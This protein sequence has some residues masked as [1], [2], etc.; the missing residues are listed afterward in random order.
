MKRFNIIFISVIVVST[1]LFAGINII[2]LNNSS[3]TSREYMVQIERLCSQIE[4]NEEYK[5]SDYPLIIN[6]EKCENT[7]DVSF[8]E[9]DNS[10]YAIR[11]I[12][13]SY[14]RFDY[15]FDSNRIN[16]SSVIMTDICLAVLL[17][18]MLTTLIFV[19]KQI[20]IPFIKLRDIPHELSKGNLTV[21]LK[22]NKNRLFGR[23]IWGLDLLREH[24]EQQKK[25]ELALIKDKKT[26]ILSISH[27]IK[28]PLS[29]IKLSSQALSKG[30]YKDSKK[31]IE[32]AKNINENAN[33]I[34]NFVTEIVKASNEEFIKFEVNNS[35][36][37]ID[38][39]ISEINRYYKEKLILNKIKFTVAEHSNHIV[40]GD[41]DRTVEVMQNIIENA[42]KYG[43]GEFIKIEFS[44]EEGCSLISISNSGCTLDDSE[45]PH[46]F[47][48]FWRGSNSKASSGSGLG[49]YICRQ[50]M[51][52]MGGEI[53]AE[54]HGT[55]IT[56]TLVLKKE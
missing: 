7:N 46:I 10:D 53:F 30:L 3:S 51:H 13:N 44:I 11:F 24:L 34:E 14:Y 19:K 16:P 31:Q 38:D 41:I 1:V 42:I 20:L 56:L 18:V 23:F 50:L 27:D 25:N 37:Y 2:M 47:D 6:I 49:L 28:T 55:V 15:K 36:F 39:C 32:V 35:E 9:G 48:S 52:L 26:L 29:A 21:P 40:K 22:E 17:I 12:K 43:N 4:S 45:M 5:L 8:F 33:K 54:K